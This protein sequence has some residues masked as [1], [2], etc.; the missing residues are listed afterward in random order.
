MQSFFPSTF[1]DELRSQVSL[2]EIAGRHVQWHAG[3]SNPSRNDWW[4]CCPFHHE[5]TP[6]FHVDDQKGFYHCFGCGAKGNA[7]SFVMAMERLSFTEA[8]KNLAEG[9]SLPLPEVTPEAIA[10]EERL[11][12]RRDSIRAALEKAQTFFSRELRRSSGRQAREHLLGRDI[13]PELWE[14]FSLGFAPGENQL[15]KYLTSNS[16]SLSDMIDAGLV[17]LDE[18]EK[19]PYER[20]RN[21]VIFPIHDASNRLIAFGGRA[22]TSD[23]RAKYLNSP[24]S[25]LFQKRDTLYNLSRARQPARE[26]QSVLLVEGYMDVIAMTLAGLTHVVAPLGTALGDR[27]I[28]LLWRLAA[29]PIVCFDG[30]SAGIRAAERV[31]QLS[32]EKLKP[33]HSMRFALLPRE[34]DPEDLLRQE[35]K[36][37][38]IRLLDNACPLDEMLWQREIAQSDWRTPE[39]RARLELRIRR[40]VARIRNDK[41]RTHY[42]SAMRKRLRDMLFGPKQEPSPS[43]AVRRSTIIGTSEQSHRRIRLLLYLGIRF[44]VLAERHAEELSAL[45]IHSSEANAVRDALLELISQEQILDSRDLQ[46]RLEEKRLN[47]I[48][49]DFQRVDWASPMLAEGVNRADFTLA[50]G[51]ELWRHVLALEKKSVTRRKDIPDAASELAS[52]YQSGRKPE[53]SEVDPL[54]RLR[55]LHNELS[56]PDG[57][58]TRFATAINPP[59]VP[60]DQDT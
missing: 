27:Q 59:E 10:E 35:G 48:I 23:A 52:I 46:R 19:R 56:N 5:K 33:G 7:I 16:V 57:S 58:E 60:Q 14:H 31:A 26:N 38:M 8:V 15:Q 42:Q 36:N 39:R 55:A 45:E 49:E 53:E 1:L 20:F 50:K 37:A 11:E 22:L 41:V 44:P 4:A 13:T 32:L 47:A 21:R 34:Q 24:E 25:L 6:S 12:R 9:V 28:D 3:K 18:Q 54:L 29:E 2:F 51:E 17:A 43:L 30:D 40:M